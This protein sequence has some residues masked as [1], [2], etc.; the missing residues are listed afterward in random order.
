[1]LLAV[2]L[3][4]AA[5][6]F[7]AAPGTVTSLTYVG[8]D[9]LVAIGLVLLTGVARLTSFGQAAFCG[10]G[11]YTTALLTTGYGWAPLATLPMSLL[12]AGLAALV[13]GAITTRLAGHYLVLGTLAWGTAVPALLGSLPGLGGF[14][15]ITSVPPIGAGDWRFEQARPV[16]LLV[17]AIV[18]L[19]FAAAA[20]LLDSRVGRAIRSLPSRVMAESLGIPVAGFKMAVFVI[21]ALLAGLAGWLQAHVLRVVNPGPFNVNASI[22]DLFMVVIG[23]V[24]SLGGALL[25]PALF[26][27]LQD[28]LRERLPALLGRAGSYEVAVFGLLVMLL[29]QTASTGLMPLLGRFLPARP[30][31]RPARRHRPAPPPRPA[32][33]RPGVAGGAA[34]ATLRRLG[35]GE[36]RQLRPARRRDPRLD[37]A[38]RR[39]KIHAVQPAHR[40]VAGR[41][42]HGSRARPARRQ[43]RR[44]ADRGAGR[45][46]DV[47]ACGASPHHVRAG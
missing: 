8:V 37:R 38:E 12:V 25:G 33:N 46:A 32:R 36:R 43:A 16:F 2:A 5:V 6:P 44:A 31:R 1:M 3:A 47:P 45:G 21:A 27:I 15:G 18:G 19:A 28:Q 10:L 9:C 22:D 41:W 23:G 42:R 7:V 13:L 39:R 30:P 17:W 34:G 29:L 26:H 14:N 11:A 40:R 35:G 24:S 4:T 20:N